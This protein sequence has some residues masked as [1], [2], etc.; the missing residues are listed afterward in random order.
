M[1]KHIGLI[2]SLEAFQPNHKH[3]FCMP[4][5]SGRYISA[6]FKRLIDQQQGFRGVESARRAFS[7]ATGY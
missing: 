7:R 6:D 5:H 2:E 3:K 4:A 1:D